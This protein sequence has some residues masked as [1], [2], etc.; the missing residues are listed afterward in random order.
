M[1]LMEEEEDIFDLVE[2]IR[3]DQFVIYL[4]ISSLIFHHIIS[5]VKSDEM[6]HLGG[7]FL[8]FHLHDTC[9]LFKCEGWPFLLHLLAPLTLYFRLIASRLVYR[10][11]LLIALKKY[12][13]DCIIRGFTIPSQCSYKFLTFLFTSLV[14]ESLDSQYV[15]QFY[16]RLMESR[17]K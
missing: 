16:E 3:F 10:S 15:I 2:M 9:H 13:C 5:M 12:N 8:A 6:W 7:S 14:L 4:I 11:F 17:E 1:E